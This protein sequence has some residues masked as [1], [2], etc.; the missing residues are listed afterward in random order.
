MLTLAASPIINLILSSLAG[1]ISVAVVFSIAIVGI[2]RASEHRR[3]HRSR[4]AAAYGVLGVLGLVL[5]AAIIVLGVVLVVH[6][7]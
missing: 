6:K 7:S 1:G 4:A 3:E 5:S 2:T